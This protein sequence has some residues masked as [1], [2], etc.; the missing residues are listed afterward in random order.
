MYLCMQLACM[1]ALY[2]DEQKRTLTNDDNHERRHSSS[3][4]MSLPLCCRWSCWVVRNMSLT[5]HCVAGVPSI[6]HAIPYDSQGLIFSTTLARLAERASFSRPHLWHWPGTHVRLE[7]GRPCDAYKCNVF[8]NVLFPTVH[9]EARNISSFH[10]QSSSWCT[11]YSIKHS[12][13][14]HFHLVQVSSTWASCA[15]LQERPRPRF[16]KHVRTCVDA[17]KHFHEDVQVV[18]G[19]YPR[20]YV[21]CLH[22][23]FVFTLNS[24]AAQHLEYGPKHVHLLHKYKPVP[25]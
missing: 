23:S 17:R 19:I 21:A 6:P 13:H 24:N 18:W 7:V 11:M 3:I 22:V 5:L 8:M 4:S 25:H 9:W 16:A 1:C 2:E 15:M 12:F 10:F 20:R 14:T